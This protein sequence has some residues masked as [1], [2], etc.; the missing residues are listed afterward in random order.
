MVGIYFL[1]RPATN[2]KWSHRYFVNILL[3]LKAYLTLN[4]W[5]LG[6]AI[7]KVP[8]QITASDF[9]WRIYVTSPNKIYTTLLS[10]R[11]S[12]AILSFLLFANYAQFT[13]NSRQKNRK[14]SQRV[15]S[16]K[17]YDLNKPDKIM[18]GTLKSFIY[19]VSWGNIP[20][21]LQSYLENTIWT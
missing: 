7:C 6:R 8:L 15:R 16:L 12:Y 10:A 18:A 20:S 1:A 14:K 5:D 2:E 9:V 4:S 21:S 3:K 17:K 11:V 13:V 19:F